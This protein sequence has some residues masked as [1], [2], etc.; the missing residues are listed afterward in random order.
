MRSDTTFK[1]ITAIAESILAIPFLGGLLIIGTLWVLLGIMLIL[2]II[3]LI[4][5]VKNKSSISGSI[6]GIVASILGVIPILGWVLH[7]ATA[8]VLW[9]FFILEIR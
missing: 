2:H 3:T 7:V 5:S 8:I 6:V 9:I 4:L 1:L